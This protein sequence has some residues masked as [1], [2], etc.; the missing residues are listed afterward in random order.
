MRKFGP[1]AGHNNFLGTVSDT[2]QIVKVVSVMS[3]E[4]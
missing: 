1:S 2:R 3:A 4:F